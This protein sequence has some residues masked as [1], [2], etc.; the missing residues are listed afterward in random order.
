MG[1][2]LCKKMQR[3]IIA[4]SVLQKISEDIVDEQDII[5][6]A[7]LSLENYLNTLGIAF[8]EKPPR[9]RRLSI[10]VTSPSIAKVWYMQ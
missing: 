5:G 9:R 8:E 2:G 6:P 4:V 3:F 1:R 7:A 10:E